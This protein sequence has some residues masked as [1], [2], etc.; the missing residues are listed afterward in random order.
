MIAL[1]WLN[2]FSSSKNAYRSEVAKAL[3]GDAAPWVYHAHDDEMVALADEAQ[4]LISAVDTL[5]RL[6]D[7]AM[8][9]ADVATAF[10]CS[11]VEV[12]CAVWR[13]AGHGDLADRWIEAHSRGDEEG[14]LHY[15]G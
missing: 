2:R 4:N 11:E 6:W 12:L 15:R 14:D 3:P 10:S 8:V 1:E 7:Q 5:C 9:E 13:E